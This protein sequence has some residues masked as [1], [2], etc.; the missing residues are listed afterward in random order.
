M[1][2]NSYFKEKSLLPGGNFS[3]MICR[4]GEAL[5]L[6][7]YGTY[8]MLFVL[9]GEIRLDFP[10]QNKW[11]KAG[12]FTVVSH[13]KLCQILPCKEDTVILR[14]N[15]PPRLTN[16]FKAGCS[17]IFQQYMTPVPILPPL[18]EWIE[19]LLEEMASGSTMDETHCQQYCKRFANLIMDYPSKILYEMYIPFYAC[20]RLSCKECGK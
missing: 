7:D 5:P 14:Y 11:V 8:P 19:S 16:F 12:H 4:D 15:P 13:E 17:A 18:W 1:N 6:S 9:Q 20:T 10:M 3:C 2:I